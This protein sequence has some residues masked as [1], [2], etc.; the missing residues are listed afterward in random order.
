MLEEDLVPVDVVLPAVMAA[1]GLWCSN[2]ASTFF[3]VL[4]GK[5]WSEPKWCPSFCTNLPDCN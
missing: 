3:K 4:H 5:P 1:P 2:L